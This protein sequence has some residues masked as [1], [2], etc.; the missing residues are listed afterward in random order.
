MRHKPEIVLLDLNLP[1]MSGLQALAKLRELEPDIPVVMVTSQSNIQSVQE[2]A[3][4]GA[5]GYVLKHNPK[6]QTLQALADVMASL[7][8]E[9]GDVAG[10][11]R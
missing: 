11:G 2:A 10:S 5:M 6:Q 4:L 3:R 7:E 1:V 8:D 9:T